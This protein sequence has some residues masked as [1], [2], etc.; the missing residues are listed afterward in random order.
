MVIFVEYVILDNLIISYLTLT[1]SSA[2]TKCKIKKI[3]LLLACVVFIAIS[4]FIPTLNLSAIYLLAF[5]ALYSVLICLI[6]VDGNKL[7]SK[8]VAF[9]FTF[10]TLSLIIYAFT[11]IAINLFGGSVSV[12]NYTL[13]FPFAIVLLAVF[14]YFKI[15]YKYFAKV[16]RSN[17]QES[18]IYDAKVEYMGKSLKLN[19][20]LDTGNS[21]H[22]QT[23]NLPIVVVPL[24]VAEKLL[25]QSEIV[26]L[27]LKANC[28]TIKDLH[29]I[30]Y[31]TAST[32]SSLMPVF[33]LDKLTLEKGATQRSVDCMIGISF[34]QITRTKDY[35]MLLSPQIVG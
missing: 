18:Y 35:D 12:S 19:A 4:L 30:K 16:K 33:R 8:F 21:L 2:I 23:T 22:D 11:N 9:Y 10:L 25:T 32:K 15:L 1:L 14:V 26:C 29:Y 17:A 7:K 28:K 31:S 5:K 34:A 3:N 27:M 13:D 20:F 24:S 6:A